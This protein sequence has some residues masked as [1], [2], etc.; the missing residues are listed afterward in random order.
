MSNK[1]LSRAELFALEIKY[2]EQFNLSVKNIKTFR[3]HDGMTGVN[4]DIYKDNKKFAHF[5]DD[6]RGGEPEISYVGKNDIEI[7]KNRNILRDL[8]TQCKNLPS[9]K[10]RF[11]DTGAT[12]DNTFYF[13]H[14]VNA[15]IN[16][17]LEEKEFAKIAKKGIVY[18]DP[19][20]NETYTWGWSYDIP[21]L[22]KVYPTKALGTV[23][24]RV[25]ELKSKG[26]VIK[27]TELLSQYGVQV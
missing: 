24:K 21:K 16:K 26:C 18:A 5:Y 4:A 14:I 1:I 15:L 20:D 27:N 9:V 23:Q 8:E 3:G 11:D 2:A 12:Y 7:Q 17:S 6:A 19:K 25:N 10:F 13:D 22:F